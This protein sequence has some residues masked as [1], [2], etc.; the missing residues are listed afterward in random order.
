MPTKQARR[1]CFTVNTPI[2]DASTPEDPIT[3]HEHLQNIVVDCPDFRYLV[4][5]VEKAPTTGRLHVQGYLELRAPYRF[6]RVLDL[7]PPGCHVEAARGDAQSNRDYCSKS[8]THVDGPYEFGKPAVLG[9]GKRSDLSHALEAISKHPSLEAAVHSDEK[10]A[11][12]YVRYHRGLEKLA[13]LKRKPVFACPP[14]ANRRVVVLWGATGSGKTHRSYQAL[15]AQYPD[16]EPYFFASNSGQ[17]FD[18]Y[19]GQRGAILDDFRGSDDGMPVSLFLR[20][21]DRY[22]VLVPY[23]GGFTPWLAET[24]YITSNVDPDA[25]FGSHVETARA[26]HRRLAEVT[27]LTEAYAGSPSSTTQ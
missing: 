8:D 17:W 10:V 9:Q 6:S 21:M 18:G 7:L 24:I 15:K 25:W 16:E 22:P 14:P 13:L 3:V 1:F 5:S 11:S 20:L 4:Y 26:V 27:Q 12:A 2:L 19:A 23:K